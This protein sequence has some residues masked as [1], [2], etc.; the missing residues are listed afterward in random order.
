MSAWDELKRRHGTGTAGAEDEKTDASTQPNTET[1]ATSGAIEALKQR[2]AGALSLMQKDEAEEK[3][4]LPPMED[5]GD[6]SDQENDV[7]GNK[8]KEDNWYTK[9]TKSKGNMSAKL[10]NGIKSLPSDISGGLYTAVSDAFTGGNTS[11]SFKKISDVMAQDG[12]L[13]EKAQKIALR[14]DT[15][16]ALSLLFSGMTKDDI[17]GEIA[18]RAGVSRMDAGMYVIANTNTLINEKIDERLKGFEGL[19]RVGGNIAYSIGQQLP[20]MLL[21]EVSAGA[22]AASSGGGLISSLLNGKVVEALKNAVK[23][24][25]QTLAMSIQAG[26]AKYVQNAGQYGNTGW[27]NYASSALSGFTEYFTENLFGFS[28]VNS[29]RR[30][31]TASATDTAVTALRKNLFNYMLNGV[32]EEGL[33]EVVAEPVEGAF[34]KLTVDPGKK[35]F[36]DGGVIDLRAMM[37][38]GFSGMVSG[39]I[40]SGASM[41]IETVQSYNYLKENKPTIDEARQ[42]NA[43]L[44]EGVRLTDEELSSYELNRA[45]DMVNEI[46]LRSAFE[47]L[48]QVNDTLPEDIRLP[49]FGVEGYS[50]VTLGVLRDHVMDAL[51]KSAPLGG[52]VIQMEQDAAQSAAQDA[53]Q[54]EPLTNEAIA[55]AMQETVDPVDDAI[56]AAE[57]ENTDA[58]NV[59]NV[60]VDNGQEQDSVLDTKK[61]D[62]TT[63][64][65][66]ENNAAQ[67]GED[68]RRAPRRQAEADSG[69]NGEADTK[70]RTE[71]KDAAQDGT[72]IDAQDGTKNDAQDTAQDAAHSA[73]QDNG[74]D[75]AQSDGKTD[76][77]EGEANNTSQSGENRRS[78]AEEKTG[79]SEG[80]EAER[81]TE[82][83]GEAQDGAQTVEPTTVTTGNAESGVICHYGDYNA[84]RYGA[85]WLAV[86]DGYG[87]MAFIQKAYTGAKGKAGDLIVPPEHRTDGTVFAYGQKDYTSGKSDTRYAVL[88]GGEFVELKNREEA[89]E[90]AKGERAKPETSEN[91]E[92][93]APDGRKET[94]ARENAPKENAPKETAPKE[95][96][97]K[98]TAPKETAPKEDAPSGTEAGGTPYERVAD[99]L[100]R[101]FFDKDRFTLNASVLFEI[102]NTAFG[103]TQAEG[104]YTVK[105]AYDAMELA[106]NRYLLENVVPMNVDDPEKARIC[107][108]RLSEFIQGMPTQTRR[109]AD[110]E[111]FQQFS[112]PPTIA[113]LA[114]LAANINSD[115]VVL[116]PSAGIG[117]LA[118]FPKAWGA[119]VAV[120]ELD[121]R[122]ASILSSM[123]FDMLTQEDALH[124]DNNTKLDGVKPSVILMNPPFSNTQGK[125]KSTNNS[126]LH[127]EAALNRLNEGGRLVA[128]LGAGIDVRNDGNDS[129]SYTRWIESLKENYTIRADLR[130]DGKN[131]T[132]Y[133]TSFNVRMLVID[134]IG[135]HEAFEKIFTG[136]FDDVMDDKLIH[137]IIATQFERNDVQMP[138]TLTVPKA[139]DKKTATETEKAPQKAPEPEKAPEKAPEKTVKEPGKEQKPA[140]KP[141]A[142]KPAEKPKDTTDQMP[143]ENPVDEA[144]AVK[145][146]EEKPKAEKREKKVKKEA[147]Q[148]ERKESGEYMT[149]VSPALP[150]GVDPG[151]AH[152]A[153]LVESIA[154]ASVPLP[155]AT[156]KPHP[157]LTKLPGARLSLSTEQMVN[158]VY[159]GQ[160]HERL[161]V[162]GERQGYLIGDGTGVGKGLQ[163]AAI[164]MDNRLKGRKKAVWLSERENLHEDAKRDYGDIG[165][166]PDDVL[167]YGRSPSRQKKLE[168]AK[169]GV[170]FTTYSTLRSKP[171]QGQASNLDLIANWI[172]DKT[173]DGVIVFD[174][175]HNI[176]NSEGRNASEQAKAGRELQERFPN[177]RILYVSA[178]AAEDVSKILYAD[179]LGLWGE[180]TAFSDRS[181]FANTIT[182][183]GT[184]A[185]ELVCRDLKA[186]GLLN[187][188]SISYDGVRYE[189]LEHKLSANQRKIYDT[190]SD[191]WQIVIRN[192]DE[193][194]RLTGQNQSGQTRGRARSALYGAMQSFYSQVLCSLSM[195]S[196]ISS[197]HADLDAGRAVVLQI[198]NTNESAQMRTVAAARETGET[199]EEL[200]FTPKSILT[201]YLQN[202]FPIWQYDTVV[203]ASG[204]ETVKPVFDSDGNPMVNKRAVAIRDAL[205]EQIAHMPIPENPLDMIFR[206]FGTDAVAEVTGRQVRIVPVRQADGST[207]L[208]EQNRG[209]T[210]SANEAETRAF[211]DGKKD[212]LIFSDAGGTG[213]SYHADRRAKNQKQ[214]VHYVLQPGWSASKAVQ[215]F[216]RTNRSNQVSKPIYRLVTTDVAGQARYISTIAKRLDT[217]GAMTKGQRQTGSSGMFN[218][219]DSLEGSMAKETLFNFYKALDAGK[220]PGFTLRELAPRMGIDGYIFDKNKQLNMDSDRLRDVTL[221]L[222]RILLLPM[223]EQTSLMQ[224]YRDMLDGAMDTAEQNGT[225]DKGLE[226]VRADKIDLLD[227]VTLTTDERGAETKYVKVKT[228][229]KPQ[230]TEDVHEF[231]KIRGFMGVYANSKGMARAVVRIADK[232]LENGDVVPNY[233]YFSPDK[234]GARVTALQAQLDKLTKLPERD[235]QSY[236]DETIKAMPEYVTHERYYLTGALLPVWNMFGGQKIKAQRMTL[237]DGRQMLGVAISKDTASHLKKHYHV[238]VE[239]KKVTPQEI[240]DGVL[241]DHKV[242]TASGIV[243][244]YARVN[245]EARIEAEGFR[246]RYMSDIMV[247]K[248]DGRYRYFIP[249]GQKGLEILKAISAYAEFQVSDEESDSGVQFMRSVMGTEQTKRQWNQTA[250]NYNDVTVEV[251]AENGNGKVTLNEKPESETLGEIANFVSNQ[252]G[253]T[254]RVGKV[255]RGALGQHTTGTGSVRITVANELP[256]IA[257]EL[258]HYLANKYGVLEG[259]GGIYTRFLSDEAKENYEESLWESEGFAEFM[260]LYLFDRDT[261]TRLWGED[262]DNVGDGISPVQHMLDKMSGA[263]TDGFAFSA[264]DDKLHLDQLA[265]MIYAYTHGN[266]MHNVTRM[267]VG[268][269]KELFRDIR[270]FGVKRT[271]EMRIGNDASHDGIIRQPIRHAITKAADFANPLITI[272]GQ[273]ESKNAEVYSLARQM[274]Y[275]ADVATRMVTNGLV[276]ADGKPV[277][278]VKNLQNAADVY[279]AMVKEAVENG[280]NRSDVSMTDVLD[281]L[282]D[283]PLSVEFEHEGKKYTVRSLGDVISFFKADGKKG[284]IDEARYNDFSNYMVAKHA[285]E[286]MEQGK[287]VYANDNITPEVIGQ[288]VE[289]WETAHPEYVSLAEFCYRFQMGMLMEYGVKSGIL[290]LDTAILFNTMY[291]YHVPL[292][293]W[294]DETKSIYKNFRRHRLASPYKRAVGSGRDIINVVDAMAQDVFVTLHAARRNQVFEQTAI[295]CDECHESARFMEQVPFP[296]Q[297]QVFDTER[298][299]KKIERHTERVISNMNVSDEVAQSYEAFAALMLQDIPDEMVKY[300]KDKKAHGDSLI[301]FRE[302]SPVL[303]EV[304]DPELMGFVNDMELGENSATFGH[305]FG[306]ITREIQANLTGRNVVWNVKNGMR[307]FGTV[308]YKWLGDAQTAKRL[309]QRCAHLIPDM[310]RAYVDSI[311]N[312]PSEV[313]DMYMALGGQHSAVYSQSDPDIAKKIRDEIAPPLSQRLNIFRYASMLGEAV[314]R[315]PREAVF[316]QAIREGADPLAAKRFAD[317]VTTDFRMK[318]SSKAVSTLN[319]FIPFFKAGVVG[320]M[321]MARWV[322]GFSIDGNHHL[323]TGKERFN[324]AMKRIGWLTG[325][326]ILISALFRALWYKDK[327]EYERLSDYTKNTYF[328]IYVGNHRFVTIPKPREWG[329]LETFAERVLDAALEEDGA[330]FNEFVS[331]ATDVLLPPFISDVAAGGINA[332]YAKINGKD[333][334]WTNIIGMFGDIVIAGPIIE[335]VANK[336]YLGRNIV[337]KSMKENLRKKD[338]YTGSTSNVAIALG[339]VQSMLSPMEIDHIL[340]NTMGVIWDTTMNLT[341]ND[342]DKRDYSTGFG[343]TFIRSD[344]YSND[345]VNRLYEQADAAL[346]TAGS[347]GDSADKAVSAYYNR[348]KSV[349]ANFN[350]LSKSGQASDASRLQM[351]DDV[352]T[353][354]SMMQGNDKPDYVSRV[355]DLAAREGNT[356]ILP[357]AVD[358]EIKYGNGLTRKLDADEYLKY[359]Q[360]YNAYYWQYAQAVVGSQMSDADA[361][362]AMGLVREQ[363]LADAKNGVIG[364]SRY[365]EETRYSRKNG[366]GT[367]PK[368]AGVSFLAYAKAAAFAVSATADKDKSGKTIPGSKKAKIER[369]IASL[370]LSKKQQAALL[371]ALT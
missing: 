333:Y 252:F 108:K 305:A 280:G 21:G 83:T 18:D 82:G 175:A 2:H 201:G 179:R 156:Y 41:T 324:I 90:A 187:A 14:G 365:A 316:R 200:D 304:H 246:A 338:Q 358:T 154:M 176:G 50:E 263:K 39:A 170:L 125:G 287:R 66:S 55:G 37:E 228:Y 95:T 4:D 273:S 371:D 98:E 301:I 16:S 1:V 249:V 254:L 352:S 308:F 127:V 184:A 111:K 204:N 6:V 145:E 137:H 56:R 339:K 107:V 349:Y 229:V 32:L 282:E 355:L 23:F 17:V 58:E 322:T 317:E 133:G 148:K 158:V 152:P 320:S 202:A 295:L 126:F 225:L 104:A 255:A 182:E 341:A 198:V 360:S 310:F 196:V 346:R 143:T 208:A 155:P 144:P 89:I 68:R 85:P 212:I 3:D 239:T 57:A 38:A 71:G 205:I 244:H 134:K 267:Q 215:G 290:S 297:K 129:V 150:A 84:R 203:D 132:K 8:E 142:E 344:I 94:E 319:N 47:Q 51:A 276:D 12:A 209:N 278:T 288:W 370:R 294:F 157:N 70:E 329:V 191:A 271:A 270:R 245:R 28:D 169:E 10:L 106:V 178:T 48:W 52:P 222:N 307:D 100:K 166:N 120:N 300:V 74:H 266:V 366:S 31:F 210:A 268:H 357:S 264:Q 189:R 284:G 283:L 233:Q 250:E 214:R 123:G 67:T 193:A 217:L 261:M 325:I 227:E 240:M 103:G 62:T 354:C 147:V 237:D 140:K 115:D 303:Y 63:D 220:I 330:S 72:Q 327:E 331:Y 141:A 197:M 117:G 336:D 165:G 224:A 174:E 235:W 199:L 27:R 311:R 180:G 77:K 211:Q 195:P 285:S 93:T 258:G 151:V 218:A 242:Y 253:I 88:R 279:E 190:M 146:Q 99:E 105:D 61:D 213:K 30:M 364:R 348:M 367:S 185:M 312:K 243:L 119:K 172:G 337:P 164:I 234:R 353:F 260:R 219:N 159:A 113:Y 231:A 361:V 34:D 130:I 194:L 29:L 181:D 128:I 332:T 69:M 160:A 350:R 167:L 362:Y 207:A 216:G 321:Q 236:W 302:G 75:D 136:K 118:L 262:G 24:N 274:P 281:N 25:P 188:R 11:A 286:R 42:M 248:I 131:Y 97:P 149:Y 22:N 135:A 46:L 221:F 334:D 247:E 314:E 177:A 122:R 315:A 116:E 318:G 80:N 299:R 238:G 9:W 259:S 326:S 49:R 296:Q 7:T 168:A 138:P 19:D 54:G 110:Q 289:Q 192:M 20:L 272:I 186:S 368:A 81:R 26:S 109:T 298:L 347:S 275:T 328:C 206:E 40:L 359:Q 163:I 124:I 36:G 256:V 351:L 91:A 162:S 171:R 369:Y 64:T 241:K 335:V 291:K 277:L 340:K 35:W 232:T 223:S 173:F 65:D 183:S 306:K 121:P 363:A 265:G 43:S 102:C 343:N 33:E 257:H 356:S 292:M 60:P 92:K 59:P 87:K 293:R 5:A 45:E 342:P 86:L 114:A 345:V 53:A 76:G 161:L 139:D 269:V 153:D 230:I 309:G 313:H 44:P 226:T 13:R 79:T 73:A 96:A 78:E 251:D 15:G 101:R 112:T 323:A